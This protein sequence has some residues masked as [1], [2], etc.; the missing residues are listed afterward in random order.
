M[1]KNKPSRLQGE[2]DEILEGQYRWMIET[3]NNAI[4]YSDDG[5]KRPILG[6]GTAPLLT[7]SEAKSALTRYI[8]RELIRGR[9]EEIKTLFYIWGTKNLTERELTVPEK[10]ARKRMVQ[11]EAELE[12][13]ETQ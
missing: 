6:T 12:E 4:K 11:L 13:L 3:V 9:I 5:L 8:K 10:L 1:T 7:P 2:L